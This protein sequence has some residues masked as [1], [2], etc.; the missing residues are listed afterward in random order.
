MQVRTINQLAT[1]RE[2]E[3][4]AGEDHAPTGC[5]YIGE[6]Y[7]GEDHGPTDCFYIG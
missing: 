1:Y 4:Y 2:V 5:F 7:A 6:S 3:S